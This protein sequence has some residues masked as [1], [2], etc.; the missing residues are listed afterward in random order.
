MTT[1]Y[2]G[3]ATTPDADYRALERRVAHLEERFERQQ[4]EA[5]ERRMRLWYRADSALIAVLLAILVYLAAPLE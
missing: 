3:G 4:R 5:A 1:G 2:R